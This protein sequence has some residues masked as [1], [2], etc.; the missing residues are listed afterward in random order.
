MLCVHKYL[1]LVA[2]CRELKPYHIQLLKHKRIVVCVIFALLLAVGHCLEKYAHILTQHSL[3][4]IVRMHIYI[5]V[6]CCVICY[7]LIFGRVCKL[8][9]ATIYSSCPSFPMQRPNSCW[10]NFFVKMF[11][12][13]Q[14][15][16]EF[17]EKIQVLL[18]QDK[19]KGHYMRTYINM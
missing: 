6:G 13:V 18:K 15:E 16:L 5:F 1:Q 11:I 9:K 10:T 17:F 4:S 7:Q 8:R 19:N 12:I 3:V 2:E 14:G